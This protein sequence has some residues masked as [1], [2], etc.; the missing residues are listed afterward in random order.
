MFLNLYHFPVEI[1]ILGQ[2]IAHFLGK[3]KKKKLFNKGHRYPRSTFEHLRARAPGRPAGRPLP[4]PRLATKLPSAKQQL[5]TYA[6]GQVFCHTFSNIAF[7]LF[8]VQRKLFSFLRRAAK[9]T[10]GLSFFPLISIFLPSSLTI[11]K[12]SSRF[13]DRRSCFKPTTTV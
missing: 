7:C 13:A 9:G 11:S 10:G 3:G 12:K 8:E 5:R 4:R 6:A 1:K 2:T